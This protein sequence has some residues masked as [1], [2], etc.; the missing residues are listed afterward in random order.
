MCFILRPE[1]KEK[2][3]CELE[4]VEF[5]RF[6]IPLKDIPY[7]FENKDIK[8]TP[9][10]EIFTNFSISKMLVLEGRVKFILEEQRFIV[11]SDK[12]KYE[13]T[14][15]LKE[16]CSCK[17]VTNYCIHIK[18]AHMA[19][20]DENHQPKKIK[21]SNILRKERGYKSGRKKP[22][23]IKE[24]EHADAG[25]ASLKDLEKTALLVPTIKSNVVKHSFFQGN[26]RSFSDLQ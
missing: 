6:S 8:I 23:N 14:L 15:Y 17:A 5:P 16:K 13:A 2:L 1:F 24:I 9:K 25:N 21:L 7:V 26:Q 4:E 20:G 11:S 10:E 18:A 22:T 12:R 3:Q 19:I